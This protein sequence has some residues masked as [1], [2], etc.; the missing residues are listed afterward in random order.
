[1]WPFKRRKK[2]EPDVEKFNRA[3]H[4]AVFGKIYTG[5]DVAGDFRSVFLRDN[6]ELGKRVLFT[7]LSWC[8]EYDTEVPSGEDLQRW[9][10]KREVAARIKA[11]LY[12]D[13]SVRS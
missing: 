6:P 3:L 12:A 9:A 13:L 10:G 2:Y 5:E 1:M 8:G 4:G 11:A 7:L